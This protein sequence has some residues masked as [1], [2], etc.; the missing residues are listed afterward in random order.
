MSM[1]MKYLK[2]VYTI[3]YYSRCCFMVITAAICSKIS[4]IQYLVSTSNEIIEIITLFI[5]IVVLA[6]PQ[7]LICAIFVAP[8][9]SSVFRVGYLA[10]SSEK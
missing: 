6:I 9:A 8:F 4:T 2:M 5:L 1:E 10:Y 3:G 7:A